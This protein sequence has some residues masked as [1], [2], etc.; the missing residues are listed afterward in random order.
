MVE[1]SGGEPMQEES[2]A[3]PKVEELCPEE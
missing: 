1:K 2:K 3:Q